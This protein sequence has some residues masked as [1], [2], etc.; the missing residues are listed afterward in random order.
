MTIAG[1]FAI[2]ATLLLLFCATLGISQQPA[3]DR[4]GGR[5]GEFHFLLSTQAAQ[6]RSDFAAMRLSLERVKNEIETFPVDVGTRQ[7]LREEILG[8]ERFVNSMEQQLI[9]PASPTAAQAET[10]LTAAKGQ[11]MCGACHGGGPV[12]Q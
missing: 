3:P 7:R 10:R 12:R 9:V 1:R 2:F 4:F 8:W 5:P 11:M 6:N